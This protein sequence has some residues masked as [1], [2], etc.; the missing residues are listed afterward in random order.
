MPTWVR[1]GSEP[2][3]T[4]VHG[5]H[6]S[7]HGILDHQR[8]DEELGPPEHRRPIRTGSDRVGS[9]PS[10]RSPVQGLPEELPLNVELEDGPL[11]VGG[12]V[13]AAAVA[14]QERVEI[15]LRREL[16]TSHEDHWRQNQNLN[17]TRP[18]G[19]VRLPA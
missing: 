19:G 9:V 17:R 16:L 1:T 7:V 4:A 14:L 2:G 11:A 8:T 3:L 18:S 5:L 10:L 15:V 6:L 12:R 13:V